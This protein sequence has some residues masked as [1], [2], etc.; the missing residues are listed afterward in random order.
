MGEAGIYSFQ[1]PVGKERVVPCIP[2]FPK[3]VK[4]VWAG[5]KDLIE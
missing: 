3:I 2:S 1:E 5:I 4:L